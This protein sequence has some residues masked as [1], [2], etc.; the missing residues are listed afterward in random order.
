MS[1][2][3]VPLLTGCSWWT[4]QIEAAPPP[5]DFCE[6]ST[7][8]EFTQAEWDARTPYPKNLRLDIAER[9]LHVKLCPREEVEDP[10]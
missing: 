5:P 4:T 2:L 1:C 8:R 6:L 9:E 10:A 3:I 7:A